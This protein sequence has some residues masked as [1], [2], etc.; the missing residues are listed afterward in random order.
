MIDR[1]LVLFSLAMVGLSVWC[2]FYGLTHN[3]NAIV[4]A[5]LFNIA[6]WTMLTI[7]TARNIDD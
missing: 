4:A 2:A 5:N 6:I 1:I 7:V 3:D